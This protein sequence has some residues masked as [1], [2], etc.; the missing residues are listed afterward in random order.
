MSTVSKFASN[1]IYANYVRRILEAATWLVDSE[2]MSTVSKYASN[3]I[4]AMSAEF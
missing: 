3:L 2:I 1:L 4:Y